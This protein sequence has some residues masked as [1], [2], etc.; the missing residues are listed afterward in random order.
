MIGVKESARATCAIVL[1]KLGVILFVL[2]VGMGSVDT[3]NWTPFMPYGF[4]GVGAAAAIVFFAY[5]GF[6]AVST[7]AEGV[8]RETAA[9]SIRGTGLGQVR[10]GRQ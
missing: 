9:H 1:V 6:D 4:D 8:R 10:R 5:V 3:A 7:T 2:A